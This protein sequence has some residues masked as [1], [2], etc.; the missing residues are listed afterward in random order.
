MNGNYYAVIMAGGVG[1][2][3]WPVST[4]EFPKQFHDMLGTGSTL[5]Q[6]TYARFREMLP[7]ENILVL[8]NERYLSLVLEQL[9]EIEEEQVLTEP[10]MRNTA[11]CI[12]YAAMK[13]AARN[14]HGVMAVAPSDHWIEQ[15]DLFLNNIGDCY[16]FCSDHPVLMTLG[17]QPDFPNTGYGYIQYA[18][19]YSKGDF[20][21]VSHFREKPDR[22]TATRYIEQ[23]NYLWNAG[24]FIWSVKEI[25]KAFQSHQPAMYEVF[26][27]GINVYGTSGERLFINENYAKAENISIDY[28]VMEPADNIYVLPAVFKWNDLGTW[29]SLYK[30][31]P[32]LAD[33]N[34]VVNAKVVFEESAGNMV[35]TPSG[36]KVVVRGLQDYII[37]DQGD[38]LLIY[39][40]DREQDVKS[41]PGKF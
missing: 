30:E 29:G 26:Q 38:T 5:L 8:T 35:Y 28:A 9:P 20:F 1:S 19:E 14:P 6:T 33:G 7:A 36:K 16:A 21:K 10:V 24:I 23:G 40:K 18:Q 3:F 34:A 15:K 41:L 4:E 12:L 22:A 11:P 39:P 27:Q 17:I 13:I 25:L 31:L 37:V 2:R 32:H